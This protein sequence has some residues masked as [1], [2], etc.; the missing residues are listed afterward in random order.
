[1][2]VACR[3]G[4]CTLE[5]PWLTLLPACPWLTL[6]GFGFMLGFVQRGPLVLSVAAVSCLT[7][8]QLLDV[9][10]PA[11]ADEKATRQTEGFLGGLFR[12]CCRI[13]L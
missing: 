5:L 11:F 13:R 8:G 12:R 4:L 10:R 2:L 9:Q 1:M 3:P 6:L 7:T